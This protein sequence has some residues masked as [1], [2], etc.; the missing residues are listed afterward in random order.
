MTAGPLT[1]SGFAV[2]P[3]DELQRA[4]SG[5][6]AGAPGNG[7]R[8]LDRPNAGDGP[9]VQGDW[10]PDFR[11]DSARSEALLRRVAAHALCGIAGVQSVPN[12][13]DWDQW[14]QFMKGADWRHP[15]GPKSNI[16]VHDNH[17]FPMRS[18]MPD[19]PARTC[20]RKRNGNS[21]RAA[22]STAPS[23]R[24]AITPR[25]RAPG[26][27]LAGRIPPEEFERGL[28]RAHL[29]GNDLSAERLWRPGHDR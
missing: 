10:A 1:S 14:W 28:L 2:A 16:K 11:R 18:L 5:S 29:A 8:L 6:S 13:R 25:W 24:G 21:P 15:D 9:A 26:Q 27:H 23:S 4:L 19:G 22:A 3:S 12:V 20:R 17:P 7:G